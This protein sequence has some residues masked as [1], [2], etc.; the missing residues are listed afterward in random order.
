MPKWVSEVTKMT[1]KRRPHPRPL[2]KYRWT[3]IPASGLK[4]NLRLAPYLK[5]QMCS[6]KLYP[7]TEKL[8]NSGEEQKKNSVPHLGNIRQPEQG[9]LRQPRQK[10]VGSWAADS[11]VRRRAGAAS[12]SSQLGYLGRSP[13]TFPKPPTQLQWKLKPASLGRGQETR[14]LA[15]ALGLS[16]PARQRRRVTLWKQKT[17]AAPRRIHKPHGEMKRPS[18]CASCWAGFLDC[19]QHSAVPSTKSRL[20]LLSVPAQANDTLSQLFPSRVT[21]IHEI[22]C[23]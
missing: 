19:S 16:L 1:K 7:R 4:G 3:L 23:E 20:V 17:H 10:R 21:H 13:P 2:A 18:L 15:L 12:G 22:T 5:L 9:K 11:D 6:L 8:R 14:S